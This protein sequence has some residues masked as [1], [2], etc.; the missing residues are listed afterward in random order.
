MYYDADRRAY[1][2]QALLKQ[3]FYNYAYAVNMQGKDYADLSFLEGSHWQTEND[4]QILVY[5]REIGSRYD[6]LVGFATFSSND[7]FNQND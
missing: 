1:R 2:C 7:L 5:N 3:G 4:Y 6:R